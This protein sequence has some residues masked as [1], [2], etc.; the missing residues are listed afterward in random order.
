MTL[1]LALVLFAPALA[2]PWA[3]VAPTAAAARS[4]A[5]TG[6]LVLAA[7]WLV[8]VLGDA[9]ATLGR[10]AAG[11]A[12]SAI[13]V[14]L[15]V[16][17]LTWPTQR[18]PV[19][20]AFVAGG[21][22]VGGLALLA[23][24]GDASDAAGALAIAA[25]V[26]VLGARRED[27]GGL[28]LATAGAVGAGLLSLGV[29]WDGVVLTTIGCAVIAGASAARARRVGSVVLPAA[30][31]LGIASGGG[32]RVS[33]ALGVAGAVLASRPAVALAM[34]SLA[35]AAAGASAG[36]SLLGASAVLL[37]V[38]VNPIAAVAALPGA[39]SSVAALADAGDRTAVV[40]S[41][42][43]VVTVYRL[44][45]ARADARAGMPSPATTAALAA[46]AWLLVAPQTWS[47]AGAADL[48]GW[49]TGVLIA[50]AGT[51]VGVFVVA[52]FTETAF[53]VPM[54]D[55]VD[56][57]TSVGDPRWARRASVVALV[58]L[59]GCGGVLV[60]SSFA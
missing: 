44:V 23:G 24:R 9:H 50:A 57:A 40:L 59:A 17:A 27:D 20:V 3:R 14:W 56:P 45:H 33:V 7:G 5:S 49:R 52:S 46:E 51:A 4:A 12:P 39:A 13:G 15:L 21:V 25:A 2:L 1:L 11:A 53:V 32:G 16:A 31:V 37:A 48:R 6:A 55:A 10:F 54:L 8:L 60:A 43:A 29:A 19:V 22:T 41:L 26:V 36:A 18:V 30:L 34:W 58:A 42:L 38:V 47:W 35:V 28:W